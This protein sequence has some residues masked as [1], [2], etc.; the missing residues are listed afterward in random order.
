[1]ATIVPL[2]HPLPPKPQSKTRAPKLADQLSEQCPSQIGPICGPLACAQDR[3]LKLYDEYLAKKFPDPTPVKISAS[4]VIEPSSKA[5]PPQV[6]SS[7]SKIDVDP[8]SVI[9]TFNL[10]ESAKADDIVSLGSPE[11]WGLN[12]QVSGYDLYVYSPTIFYYSL[13]ISA[14]SLAIYANVM[15]ATRNFVA[16]SSI[17]CMA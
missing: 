12:N 9:N 15:A 1:M 3:A 16:L 6:Q 4:K 10:E 17:I 8:S 2:T 7:P 13:T 11:D 14:Q 5:P